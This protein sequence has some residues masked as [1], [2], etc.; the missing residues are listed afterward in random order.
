MAVRPE[1][2]SYAARSAPE[3]PPAAPDAGPSGSSPVSE[4]AASPSALQTAG[5]PTRAQRLA[6]E[7]TDELFPPGGL[8]RE[9][10]LK[11]EQGA[12]ALPRVAP[13]PAAPARPR[14]DGGR[15]WPWVLIALLPII[16]IVGSGIWLF[17][18]LS[19]A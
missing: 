7:P 13:P 16:V 17:I 9:P 10:T 2:S 14:N 12:G 15:R 1:W 8:Q 19:H 6:S 11:L 5:P 3:A 18:L 4:A